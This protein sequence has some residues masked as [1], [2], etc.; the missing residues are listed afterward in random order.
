LLGTWLR[1]NVRGEHVNQ[2]ETLRQMWEFYKDK[3]AVGI[4]ALQDCWEM[5]PK[6][7]ELYDTTQRGMR[8]AGLAEGNLQEEQEI[9]NAID[10]LEIEIK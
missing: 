7:L 10:A 2:V 9:W 4:G 1:L 6:F 8:Y 3:G 5:L